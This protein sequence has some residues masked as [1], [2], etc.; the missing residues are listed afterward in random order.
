MIL[1]NCADYDRINCELSFVSVNSCSF[2]LLLSNFTAHHKLN[3]SGIGLLKTEIYVY[4]IFKIDFYL[5]ERTFK[6]HKSVLFELRTK[7]YSSSF[8]TISLFV[9]K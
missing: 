5:A 3:N 9:G 2:C 6:Q 4:Y 8:I 7:A 1:I